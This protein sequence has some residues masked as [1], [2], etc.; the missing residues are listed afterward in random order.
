VLKILSLEY[1]WPLAG[2][3][4]INLDCDVV[5]HN[6]LVIR[7]LFLHNVQGM[8]R[9]LNDLQLFRWLRKS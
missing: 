4:R 1:H 5:E 2:R 8:M 7:L 6:Q 3:C 9:V